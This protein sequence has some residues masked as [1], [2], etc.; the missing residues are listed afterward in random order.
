MLSPPGEIRK[1]EEELSWDEYVSNLK[2]HCAKQH[3]SEKWFEVCK[4]LSKKIGQ[5]C[6]DGWLSSMV[7]QKL[8][9][10]EVILV[11]PCRWTAERVWAKENAWIR[12]ALESV[13]PNLKRYQVVYNASLKEG[14]S[15]EKADR[16]SK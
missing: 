12:V 1:K 3:P 11:Y 14:S 6:F 8:E 16:Y 2:V 9:E 15:Y 4:Y 10:D 5:S 7:P 13:F